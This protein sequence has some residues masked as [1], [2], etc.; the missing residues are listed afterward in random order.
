[1]TTPH[2]DTDTRAKGTDGPFASWEGDH[3]ALVHVLWSARHQ[4]LTLANDTD[5]IASMVMRSRFLAANRARP[6][7]DLSD[8][9]GGG[10]RLA[11]AAQYEAEAATIRAR[12]DAE[13]EMDSDDANL[14]DHNACTLERLAANLRQ[15][16]SAP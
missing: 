1:M 13:P 15:E 14:L 2:L 10:D 4:G 11:L 12:L 6:T 5:A 9:A 8:A 3:T 7:A 16:A